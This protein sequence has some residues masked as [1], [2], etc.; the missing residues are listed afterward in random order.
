MDLCI[1]TFPRIGEIFT[2]EILSRGPL[3][4]IFV[5][6]EEETLLTR[7]TNAARRRDP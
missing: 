1:A 6:M 7:F 5:R 4:Q 2:T 3:L